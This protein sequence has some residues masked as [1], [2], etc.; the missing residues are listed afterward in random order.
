MS[1]GNPAV[2]AVKRRRVWVREPW[3]VK[4]TPFLKHGLPTPVSDFLSDAFGASSSMDHWQGR[5]KPS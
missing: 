2:E 5:D 4:I 1:A 3:I